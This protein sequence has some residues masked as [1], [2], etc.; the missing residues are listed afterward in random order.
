MSRTQNPID[1][2]IAT[3]RRFLAGTHSA[4]IADVRV[5]DDTVV[6]DI[7]CHGFPG[8][9]NPN[10]HDSY[11]DFFRIF[12]QS[13]GAMQFGIDTLVAD[14]DFV[15]ARWHVDCIH[16]GPFAGIA[17]TGRQVHFTGMVLYRMRDGLIAETWLHVDELALLGQIG[18]L[19]QMA[20]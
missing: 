9:M 14:K 16:C 3:V 15:S 5:I 2:N 11:K 19:P 17:A 8:G 10:S 6:P 4:D 18:A 20:A 1:R 13:F 7:V 12:R